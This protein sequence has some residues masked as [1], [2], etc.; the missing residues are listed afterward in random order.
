MTLLKQPES[1]MTSTKSYI[2]ALLVKEKVPV[3]E[4][5][6]KTGASKELVLRVIR[7][8]W[9]SGCH[10]PGKTLPG[11][12]MTLCWF[13]AKATGSCSWSRAFRP[14]PGWDAEPTK[15][16]LQKDYKT[17]RFMEDRSYYVKACPEFE[18]DG[19]I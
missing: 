1:F 12:R 19:R 13:C 15:I 2:V 10:Y 18:R 4:I 14:V 6:K 17:G 7:G 9:G 3:Y 5:M 11:E 16:K 8:M